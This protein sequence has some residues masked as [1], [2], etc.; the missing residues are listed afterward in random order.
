MRGRKQIAGLSNNDHEMKH[1]TENIH[2]VWAHAF[3]PR[4]ANMWASIGN[5][6]YAL[7]ST[8]IALSWTLASL[9]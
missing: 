6:R 1:S 9:G 7:N 8:L 2:A 5:P 3:S 4:G